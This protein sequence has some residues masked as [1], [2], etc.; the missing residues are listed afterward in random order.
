MGYERVKRITAAVLCSGFVLGAVA[1]VICAGMLPGGALA[2][3]GKNAVLGISGGQISLL[4]SVSG[5]CWPVF[6]AI[7]AGLTVYCRGVYPALFF[8][9]GFAAAYS[10]SAVYSVF[11]PEKSCVLALCVLGIKNLLLLAGL[12]LLCMDAYAKTLAGRRAPEGEQCYKP[13]RA[14]VKRAIISIFFA[15]CAAFVGQRL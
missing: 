9:R 15:A 12:S 10:I 3:L 5:C 6:A 7:A 14:F 11:Q 1:G 2:E 13:D 8:V 4:R